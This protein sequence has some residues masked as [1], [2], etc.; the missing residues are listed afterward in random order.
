MKR[1]IL[2]LAIVAM[3]LGIAGSAMAQEAPG[4]PSYDELTASMGFYEDP[5]APGCYFA[6]GLYVCA[7]PETA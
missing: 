3:T 2:I 7:P 5:A 4:A 1:M 6:F